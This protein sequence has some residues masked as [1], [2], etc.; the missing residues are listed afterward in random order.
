MTDN[1]N[2]REKT[3][4]ELVS[5]ALADQDNFLYLMRR[6]EGKLLA[7][8]LRISSFSHDEAEDILQEVFI[9]IYEN[10]N[11]FDT[12]LKFSSWAYRITHNQVISHYRKAKVRPQNLPMDINDKILANLSS[13][14]DIEKRVEISYL[15]KAIENVLANL[16]I[17]YREV[18]VL[19]FLEERSYQE[20]S[21]ILKKPMG[22]VATLIN[23]AKREFKEELDRQKIKI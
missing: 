14:L 4:E 11:D 19:K 21:D 17:K 16:D 9:K 23:R 13:D 12:S 10:L 5:L 22:T 18:L 6:Y 7:Y 15:R 20:I 2:F 3:D 8:I 1:K